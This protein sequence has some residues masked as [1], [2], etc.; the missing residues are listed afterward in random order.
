MLAEPIVEL[1]RGKMKKYSEVKW[2]QQ[3]DKCLLLLKHKLSTAPILKY[4]DFMKEFAM[5]TD[6]SQVGLG[7][8]LTQDYKIE[9]KKIFM[10][11]LYASRSLKGAKRRYSVTDLEALAVV[12]ALKT[13]RSYVMG[14]QFKVVTDHNALKALVSKASLEG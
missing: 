14:T 4:P 1:T 2:D 10:P 9:G 7:A 8:V 5:E 6:A 11:V 12:W 3:H 13:F